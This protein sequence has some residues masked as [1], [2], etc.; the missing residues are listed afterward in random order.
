MYRS[1]RWLE[2]KLREIFGDVKTEPLVHW[3]RAAREQPPVLFVGAGLSRT[4]KAKESSPGKKMMSWWE[5]TQS[6]KRELGESANGDDSLWIAEKF[7]CL[8]GQYALHTKLREA[9]PDSYVE[10][11]PEHFA[12]RRVNW[13]AVLTLN[14]DTLLERALQDASA[15]SIVSVISQEQ[16]VRVTARSCLPVIHLHGHIEHASTIVLTLEDFRSYPENRAV[17][18]TLARQLLLQHPVLFLGFGANDPNFVAWSGW[19]RDRVG[20]HAPP[21]VRLQADLGSALDTGMEAYWSPRLKTVLYNP[22]KFVTLL[23]LLGQAVEPLD[24]GADDFLK[25]IDELVELTRVRKQDK[26]F[27]LAVVEEVENALEEKY[28]LPLDFV[29]RRRRVDRVIDLLHAG[30]ER[31]GLAHDA[32]Q[33]LTQQSREDTRRWLAAGVTRGDWLKAPPDALPTI[34]EQK[35]EIRSKMAASFLPWLVSAVRLAGRFIPLSEQGETRF[36]A[37][38]EYELST[39]PGVESS[40]RQLGLLT[41]PYELE[42]LGASA[43]ES[44]ALRWLRQPSRSDLSEQECHVL[45]DLLWRHQLLWGQLPNLIPEREARNAQAAR[46]AGYLAAMDGRFTDAM[47]LYYRAANL[48]VAEQEPLPVQYMTARSAHALLFS[49]FLSQEENRTNTERRSALDARVKAL[50]NQTRE[51]QFDVEAAGRDQARE[52]AKRLSKEVE[53]LRIDEPDRTIL[54]TRSESLE[55]VLDYY[56]EYWFSPTIVARTADDVGVVRWEEDERVSAAAL[57]ARYGSDELSARVR[58]DVHSPRKDALPVLLLDELQRHPRWAH[59]RRARVAALAEAVTELPAS[60]RAD[61]FEYALESFTLLR[62]QSLLLTHRHS[63]PGAPAVVLGVAL[64]RHTPWSEFKPWLWRLDGAASEYL[65][66]LG[67]ANWFGLPLKWWVRND[68]FQGEEADAFFA[69]LLR[70]ADGASWRVSHVQVVDLL[71]GMILHEQLKLP[72]EGVAVRGLR[73]WLGDGGTRDD[74]EEWLRTEGMVALGIL[75][76]R[77]E[78]DIYAERAPILEMLITSVLDQGKWPDPYV[79]RAWLACLREWSHDGAAIAYRLLS[80][81]FPMKDDVLATGR[82]EVERRMNAQVRLRLWAQLPLRSDDER[83]RARTFLELVADRIPAALSEFAEVRLAG[84]D[85][86]LRE[87]YVAAVADAFISSRAHREN[88]EWHHAALSSLAVASRVSSL[89]DVPTAWLYG[90]GTLTTAAYPRVAAYACVVVR[91]LLLRWTNQWTAE[92]VPV[93]DELRRA[94]V[95]ASRDGRAY[96]VAAARRALLDAAAT[97]DRLVRDRVVDH[98]DT[99]HRLSE[100]EKDTRLAVVVAGEPWTREL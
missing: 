29:A 87:A 80:L 26:T 67:D 58:A 99:R 37:M 31:S 43:D 17:F 48:S 15:R 32:I 63:F 35:G 14:Y 27:F 82:T 88:T 22:A 19:I 53:T 8:F 77:P 66:Q 11:G 50:E 97:T 72:T 62:E 38:E 24:V 81:P 94:L 12:L 76:G 74:S 1:D 6:L 91:M 10:P 13:H 46:L 40:V 78:A 73:A 75:A 96:V 23:E 90:A 20:D 33:R 64:G 71:S 65:S 55:P 5:L 18:L 49:G 7:R 44:A 70:L 89:T 39:G 68:C 69:F 98:A 45:D 2:A 51:M 16:A 56:E 83:Q 34:A 54:R 95:R 52:R 36:D 30:L 57:L 21:W 60:K 9:V 84:V 41:L 3:I 79:V 92:H 86:A 4:A 100:L 28:P 47:D 61:L 93:L 59:E 85:A 42:R 25:Y